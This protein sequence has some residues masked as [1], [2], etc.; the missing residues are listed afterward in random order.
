MS[1][2]GRDNPSHFL[3]DGLLNFFQRQNRAF[4]LPNA[5][6]RDLNFSAE[7]FKRVGKRLPFA[8]APA[9]QPASSRHGFN[10]ALKTQDMIAA[11][12]ILLGTGAMDSV[13]RRRARASATRFS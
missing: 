7:D 5:I 6:L 8:R 10:P 13:A 2:A 4:D 11:G 1:F 3:V 12:S 9:G